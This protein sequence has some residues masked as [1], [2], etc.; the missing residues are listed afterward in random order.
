MV[1]ERDISSEITPYLDSPEAIVITGM[2]RTGKTTLLR[3]LYERTD[4]HNKLFIDLENPL[5]RRY[6]E[7]EDYERVKQHFELLGI[8]LTER[9]FVF[10]DEIQF[11][12]NGP[13]VVKYLG[14]HYRTK[15]FLTGSSSYYLKNLFSESLVGRKYIFELFP[16]NFREFLRF[17]GEPLVVPDIAAGN[18]VSETVFK[19]FERHY[20][21]YLTFGGFPG[22]VAKADVKEKKRALD[23]IFSS[24]YQ[25]EVIQLGDF[26]KTDVIRNL[27]ALLLGRVGSKLDMQKLASELS[28]SRPTLYEYLSFLSGTYF[29]STIKPFSKSRDVEVRGAEKVYACDSGLV[30]HVAQVDIG[31]LF[32]QNVFQLLRPR[33]TVHYYQRRGGSEVD[34]ILNRSEAYEVKHHASLQDVKRLERISKSLGLTRQQVISKQYVNH[35]GTGYAFLL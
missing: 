19:T 34:F 20:D 33:G 7:E 5:Q 31:A 23:D 18:T 26:R 28:I 32:E 2:R 11:V 17:K 30:N 1:I 13:S 35:P 8:N 14:D 4:S 22:V 27:M 12:K 29:V 10:L 21:E 6:F 25:L 16:F 3:S 15:F 24:Y 9:A